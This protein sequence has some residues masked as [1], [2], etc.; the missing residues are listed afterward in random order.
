MSTLKRSLS[1]DENSALTN[2][3]N[4]QTITPNNS[5]ECKKS[6]HSSSHSENED[7][8]QIIN[9]ENEITNGHSSSQSE[10]E[11]EDDDDDNNEEEE[12]VTGN[13][14]QEKSL[15][16]LSLQTDFDNG[17]NNI[18]RY[19]G[20]IIFHIHFPS[21]SRSAQISS[22]STLIRTLP[23]TLVAHIKPIYNTSS[24]ENLGDFG[25][26]LKCT[27]DKTIQN[28]SIFAKA[29]ITLLHG[30]D[31][32]KNIVK[33]IYHLFNSRE[34][35]WGFPKFEPLK[36]IYSEYV[37]AKDHTVRIVAKIHVDPPRNIEWN[38][39]EQTGFVGLKNI[40]ATCYMNSFLQTIY[41]IKKL[42]K[43]VYTLPTDSDDQSHSIPLALQKLFYDLQCTDRAV[44]TKRLT[45]SFGWDKPDEF[46]Q[47]D[48]QEFCRVLLDKLE[49]KMEGTTTEGIIPSL[50]QGEYVQYVRCT[51]VDHESRVQQTFYDVPLQVRN[52]ANITESFRN[53]C[54]SEIL[55]GENL[56]DA[57]SIHGLQEAEKGVKFQKFPPILCLHLLRFE[58]DYN[59]SQNRKINDNYSFDYHLDLSEFLEKPN[60]SSSS[61][62]LLS[63]LVHSGD[64]SSGHYV[65]FINPE[66]NEEW[67]K[68]DDD[69]VARVA[70]TDAMERNF[71]GIQD[72]DGIMYNTSAYMLVYIRDD[73]QKDVLCDINLEDIPENL[74]KRF[75]YDNKPVKRRQVMSDN[76]FIDIHLIFNDDFFINAKSC[77]T[78]LIHEAYVKGVNLDDDIRLWIVRTHQVQMN[79]NH[80]HSALL[81]TSALTYCNDYNKKII[82]LCGYGFSDRTVFSVYIEQKIFIDHVYQLLPYQKDNDI[83]LFVRYY[84][85]RD[86]SLMY[87]GHFIFP[88]EQIF[89]KCL[90][91]IALRLKMSLLS[92][93]T[94]IV[95]QSVPKHNHTHQYELINDSNFDLPLSQ[96]LHPCL[97]GVSIIVQILDIK[98]TDN[99]DCLT[100]VDDY[101]RNLVDRQE[102]DVYNRDSLHNEYLFK[103]F[104]PMKTSIKDVIRLIAERIEYPEQQIVVQKFSNSLTITSN[105]SLI[106]SLHIGCEQTLRDFYPN[107]RVN[108]LSPRKLYFKRLPFHYTELEHRRLFRLFVVNAR[109][110][111]EQRE[112]QFFVKKSSTVADFLT[113]IKQ[114][115]PVLYSETGSQELR[116][117]ELIMINQINLLFQLRI[118]PNESSTNEYINCISHFYHIEEVIP[119]EMDQNKDSV[120]IPIAYYTKENFMQINFQK[121][122]PFFLNVMQNES[123]HDVKQR[124]QTRLGLPKREFDK[125][126]FI[127]LFCI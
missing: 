54:K 97:S 85:P 22:S 45:Q 88:Q 67:F 110:K 38:S 30:T 116:M 78:E 6:R 89:Q 21:Q 73:C 107:V 95:H 17:E 8:T 91:D 33:K 34:E 119:N 9:Q 50:F 70:S 14:I 83:L 35:D 77:L 15:Q 96:A 59:L 123:V 92:S 63:I 100:T 122:F 49:C 52:N 90:N 40:G 81:F 74:I 27:M 111:E 61:Y 103:L 99:E 69:V 12:E 108:V 44:S 60:C 121:F 4:E 105:P 124:L 106:V 10:T 56:Y 125:V 79:H 7:D 24:K 39:K 117:I 62:K 1:A 98:P 58:Y 127:P 126:R 101:L 82:D 19:D 41:F 75:N 11:D 43:A 16:Y 71:G 114:W 48:I 93:S 29:E 23:W 55:T 68:F 26:F 13:H 80:Y 25:L 28:W 57:G 47:H 104:L 102:F 65:S 94:F 36:K 113:E 37:H 2:G 109:K 3:D 64:N 84:T 87:I 46:C 115:M 120:L 53:F 51:K 31:P 5:P 42:R 72:D 18:F 86:E 66:L 32:E 76:S 118:C 20:S 112:V